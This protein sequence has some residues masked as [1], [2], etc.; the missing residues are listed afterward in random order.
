MADNNDSP[1]LDPGTNGKA[2]DESPNEIA[3][4]DT[5]RVQRERY[6]EPA[7]QNLVLQLERSADALDYQEDWKPLLDELRSVHEFVANFTGDKPRKEDVQPVFLPLLRVLRT[8]ISGNG[9]SYDPNAGPS[10][11][12]VFEVAEAF[13]KDPPEN[14]GVVRMPSGRVH[15]SKRYVY[16]EPGKEPPPGYPHQIVVITSYPVFIT[17]RWARE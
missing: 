17:L 6:L 9:A 4:W 14:W 12:D 8:M 13:S 5:W 16:R 15:K 3:N 10:D 1:S 2:S 7:F 11:E